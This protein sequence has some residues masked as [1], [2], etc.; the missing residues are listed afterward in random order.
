MLNRTAPQGRLRVFFGGKATGSQVVL[1][2]DGA[3]S[4][5][6]ICKIVNQF[7]IRDFKIAKKDDEEI[8]A[9]ILKK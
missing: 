5:A 1:E 2:S 7:V 8:I 6:L 4:N 3:D 9:E